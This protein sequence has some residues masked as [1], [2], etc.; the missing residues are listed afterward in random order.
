MAVSFY[1][2][3]ASEDLCD[4]A[5]QAALGLDLPAGCLEDGPAN[6]LKQGE[7]R[8]RAVQHRQVLQRTC[9]I[10]HVLNITYATHAEKENTHALQGSPV[11]PRKMAPPAA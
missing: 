7:T 8:F 6:P 2:F 4:L 11:R 1:G 10:T 5:L 3:P 9:N